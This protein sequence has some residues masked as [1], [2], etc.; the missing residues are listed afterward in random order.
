MGIWIAFTLFAAL[1][2]ARRREAQKRMAS[3]I[4]AMATT[5]VR[6]L[7]GLPFAA[8]YIYWIVDEM[9]LCEVLKGRT[10]TTFCGARVR[11]A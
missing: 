3:Y 6:Y 4:S 8:L 2:Y 7:F 11:H 9:I 1:M 10:S 5:L